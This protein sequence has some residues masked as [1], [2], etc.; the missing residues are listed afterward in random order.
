[1]RLTKEKKKH[2]IKLIFEGN[3]HRPYLV[4]EKSSIYLE[5]FSKFIEEINDVENT[6][7][8]RSFE[9]IY[10]RD[11]SVEEKLWH[12]GLNKKT[13]GDTYGSQS[14]KI[15]QKAIEEIGPII[16]GLITDMPT[17]LREVSFKFKSKDSKNEEVYNLS[18]T[19]FF[20]LLLAVSTRHAA[21][22]GGFASTF[23]KQIEKSLLLTLCR[24]YQLDEKNYHAWDMPDE[25]DFN[26]ETDFYIVD[27]RG[28]KHKIEMKMMGRGNPEGADS[29]YA[30]GT[31]IFIADTLS[32]TNKKQCDK[33]NVFWIELK[34]LGWKKFEEV[35][36][37]L[38]IRT[39]FDKKYKKNLDKILEVSCV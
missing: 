33:N 6:S 37:A 8:N 31:K 34:D 25:A 38:E 2:I 28:R 14:Q 39:N 32:E 27:N 12:N 36:K 19:D 20:R 29:L 4:S 21:L 22:K 10:L 1:M 13:I 23:G 9:N 26:R 24:V 5:F 11:K 16:R 17:S 3:S 15:M 35:M 30:R 7:N 18:S